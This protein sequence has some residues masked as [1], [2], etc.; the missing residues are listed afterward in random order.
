[1]VSIISYLK[2]EEEEEEEEKEITGYEA[3]LF[4]FRVVLTYKRKKEE[5]KVKHFFT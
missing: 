3:H 5:N 1:M 2:E 4:I